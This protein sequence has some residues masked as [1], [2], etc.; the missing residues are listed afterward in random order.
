[1][2]HRTRQ[3][4]GCRSVNATMAMVY[5]LALEAEKSWLGLRGSNLIQLVLDGAL[6]ED[7]DLK[8]AA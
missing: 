4:K 5:K 7:G 2:R 3:T 6:F 1:M 8:R